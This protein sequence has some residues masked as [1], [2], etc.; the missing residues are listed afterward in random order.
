MKSINNKMFSSKKL[1]NTSAIYG[2]INTCMLSVGANGHYEH[3]GDKEDKDPK[4]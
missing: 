3:D 1:N 2:G 4:Q